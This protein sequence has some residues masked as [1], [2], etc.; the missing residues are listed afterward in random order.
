[1]FFLLVILQFSN[2][3]NFSLSVN[4]MS[5]RGH[6]LQSQKGALSAEENSGEEN[7][8]GMQRITGGIKIFFGGL[9][10][11]LKEEKEK[12][13]TLAGADGVV[14]VNPE[15]MLV[16]GNAARF[17]LPGG[18]VLVF[19]SIESSRGPELQINAAFAENISEVIIPVT[20]RKS[21]LVKDKETGIIY[22][23]L[24]YSFLGHGQEL[25][26]G[27][28]TLSGEKTFVSYRSAGKQ[29]VLE[30]ADFIIAQSQNYENAFS[31][32]RDSSFTQW[33]RN[34]SVMQNEEDIIAYLAEALMRGG[35]A[36]AIAAIPG[37]FTA[38][39]RHSYRSA[40]FTGGIANAYRTLNASESGR[41]NLVTRLA[42]ERSLDILKEEHIID[43]LHTRSDLSLANDVIGIIN[44]VDPEMLIQEHCPGLLEA[45]ADIK[46]WR[47]EM[48]NPVGRLTEQIFNLVLENLNR[49]TEN[50][51]VYAS[52]SEGLNMDFS[53][54]LGKAITDWAQA[55]QNAEWAAIGRSLILSVLT[56]G[57]T[58][59]EFYNVLK[60][61]NYNPHAVWLDSGI[62]TWTVSP[63]V[64]T[65]Y[66]A[67][68]L[69]IDVSFPA[70]MTHYVIIRGIRPFIKIQLH[71]QDWRTDNQFE[72]Y[73]SS[74]WVYYPQDQTLILK[75]KHRT[76]LESVRVFYRVEAPPPPPPPVIEVQEEIEETYT[77]W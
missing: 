75:L 34:A 35:Y 6:F 50:D 49:D 32:W 28:I 73:D 18:T 61:G 14:S 24:L 11:S 72:R 63:A 43:Y 44:N 76:A 26:N 25:E 71:E 10:F 21:T 23:N 16:T 57:T 12:G 30:P 53:L 1:V 29:K 48:N 27:A 19:S 3:G 8:T 47:P 39:A 52:N 4:G 40:V 58:S 46:R 38:S 15:Y 33:N 20:P 13:L 54:R 77:L 60:P 42:R 51:L 37:D 62:W 68:N 45:Y 64:R 66:I 9:E 17:E 55:E 56:G 7:E 59:G 31:A 41:M 67:G 70:G 74:G 36:A 65:S 69:N 22:N 2:K 5:I